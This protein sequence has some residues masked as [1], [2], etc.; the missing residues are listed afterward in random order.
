MN[1]PHRFENPECSNEFQFRRRR[2]KLKPA[3]KYNLTIKFL[4]DYYCEK[5]DP[6]P[7]VS[8][9]RLGPHYNSIGEYFEEALT[10]EE[11]SHAKLNVIQ[12]L[13]ITLRRISI[14]PVIYSN[15]Y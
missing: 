6:V 12:Y 1:R 5:I 11:Y 10:R 13:V 9:V 3:I 7:P 8:E 4:P 14:R 15:N 2:H